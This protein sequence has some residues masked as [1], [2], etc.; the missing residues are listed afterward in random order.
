MLDMTTFFRLYLIDTQKLDS[1]ILVSVREYEQINMYIHIN[2]CLR[3]R[4]LE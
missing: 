3:K 2:E 1:S 4:E